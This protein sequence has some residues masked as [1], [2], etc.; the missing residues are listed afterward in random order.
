MFDISLS[1]LSVVGII[2]I[3]IFGPKECSNA[4]KYTKYTILKIRQFISNN[5]DIFQN[6]FNE[7]RDH[8]IDL[9]GNAQP[10]YDISDL[11]GSKNNSN[12]KNKKR[13]VSKKKL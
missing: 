5:L 9:D 2:A 10:T 13:K 8:I 6:P 11:K 3:A 1:E 7:I 12:G 4:I